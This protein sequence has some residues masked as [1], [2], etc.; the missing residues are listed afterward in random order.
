MNHP[1]AASRTT[2]STLFISRS[3]VISVL[4]VI[5]LALIQS[6][7]RVV[8]ADATSAMAH[9]SSENNFIQKSSRIDSY[10]YRNDTSPPLRDM[11]RIP[12][13]EN[14][15]DLEDEARPASNPDS[16]VIF[17][18]GISADDGLQ[19]GSLQNF[20]I[21]NDQFEIFDKATGHSI[22]GPVDVSS[23]WAGF[24]TACAD[25]SSGKAVV[26]Y[27]EAADRWVISRFAAPSTN[28]PITEECF[29]I[30]TSSDATGSYYRYVFHLGGN[31]IDSPHLDIRGDKYFMSDSV[32]NEELTERLG[33]QFFNLDRTAMLA[34]AAA[35]FTTPGIDTGVGETYSISERGVNIGARPEAPATVLT[36]NLTYDPDATFT[37]AGLTLTDITNMKAA[38]TYA[39]QQ[40][41][42]NFH[43]PI[44]VNIK[45]TA[46]AGTGTLGQ[47]STFL[48]LPTFANMRNATFNDRSSTDDNT[49]TG[50][51]GSLPSTLVDPVAGPHDYLVSTAQAKALALSADGLSND[52]TYT[53]GGGHSYTYDPLNRAVA[54][55]FD[56][57]GV[58]MHEMSEIM[59]RIGLM[60]QNLTGN[61][62]YMQM[63]LFHFTGA[64]TRG[65][66]NGSGRNFSVDNGTTLLKLWNNAA[67][68]GGDLAD[69][70]SGTNDCFNAFSSSG[71]KN[72]LSAVDIRN[73]DVIGYDLGAGTTPTNTATPTRT[74]TSTPTVTAT[75]TPT[76]TNTA[77]PTATFTPTAAFTP[78]NTATA[79]ATATAIPSCT[80]SERI[81][82]GTFEA[83]TPWPLWTVHTSTNFGTPLCNIG[84]CGTGGGAAG[85]FAGNNWAWFGGAAPETATLGQNVTIPSGVTATLSFQLRIG[86]VTTPF[87]DTLV[88]TIDGTQIASFTEPATAEPAYTLRTFDVSSFANGASHALLF[89][90]SG[91]TTGSSS[92]VVDNVSLVAGCPAATPSI[93]GTI[94]YANAAA[95]PVFISNA[96]VTG[97]GSPN[98]STVT[99]VPGAAAGQYTLTGFGAGAYTVSPSKTTG[100]N[101]I[102]SND[103]ARI[104][105]HVA[106]T[107]LLTNNSQKVSADVSNNGAISSFDAGQIA[108]FVA[109]GTG[110]GTGITGNW[111]FFLPPGPNF[112]VGASPTSRTYASVSG[113]STGENYVGILSGDVS[114]NWNNTGARPKTHG[115]E[116]PIAVNL[117][118][119]QAPAGK[120]LIVPVYVGNIANKEVISYE[121]DLRYDPNVLQPTADLVDVASTASRGL[122]AVFNS[123]E[124][125]L[126][127]V[128]LYGPMPINDEG[129]LLNLRFT[130]VGTPGSVSP[131]TWERIMFN[132]GEPEVATIDGSV[133]LSF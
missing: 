2:I 118:D 43:D 121:F 70:A 130:P 8:V 125:G 34:G 115:P 29:A 25:R 38:N 32:Y 40:F 72:D 113:N 114:G 1:V 98:T 79:T 106:S 103:A 93:S 31:F 16:K 99:A 111:R 55:K 71:V 26:L 36:I 81:G 91:P 52:G 119:M 89:T 10:S 3:F 104:A 54:G 131:L 13:D 96:T 6:G 35:S 57:I 23:I 63:D 58:S 68:N 41:T 27:D 44:N 64:G 7:G 92:F 87:T 66:N 53:F 50:A 17:V 42:S 59:G 76:R 83:G 67:V 11:A 33:S 20:K 15:T 45:I 77:T 61:P 18:S 9:D 84:V 78:T 14:K 123:K 5:A 128:V 122:I 105:Q 4:L 129:V 73:M 49:A 97:N 108:T 112:P 94:T 90:Y 107:V 88:V 124:S 85:P 101:G 37:A 110:P 22:L 39:A 30:S 65:L 12:K 60:G 74:N 75:F 127:R 19:I 120:D 132:E 117:P 109:S 48:A 100:Q 62:D 133:Q 82:D 51:T 21:V 95:P 86:T 80:P 126:I 116:L 46:V 28:K 102:S 24:D 47:S 69:W 56:Y